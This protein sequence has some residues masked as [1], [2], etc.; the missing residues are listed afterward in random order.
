MADALTLFG[1]PIQDLGPT[2]TSTSESTSGAFDYGTSGSADESVSSS[3]SDSFSGLDEA[4][5]TQLMNSI[6]PLMTESTEGLYENIDKYTQGATDLYQS[7]ADKLMR[8]SMPQY[9]EQL[10][11]KNIL[12]SSVGG[13][14]MSDVLRGI[15]GDAATKSFEAG[16]ESAAMKANIP[17]MLAPLV[18][19]G[20]Y[21]TDKSGSESSSLGSSFSE[22]TG[23]ST[24]GSTS[25]SET[26]DTLAP[27][28]L[29]KSF[30]LGLM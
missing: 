24:S 29:L 5:R 12:N 9:L 18:Q 14:A 11:S 19:L 7:S 27:F 20:Q 4:T 2:S 3:F 10:A 28:E 21:S 25:E 23:E 1:Q 26:V 22:S 16:M 6:M 8:E 15:T 30:Y 13:G 17:S